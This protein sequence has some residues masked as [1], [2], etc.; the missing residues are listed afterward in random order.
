MTISGLSRVRTEL[1]QLLV[2]PFLAHHPIHLNG[3]FAGHRDLGDLPSPSP[4]SAPGRPTTPAGPRGVWLPRGPTRTPPSFSLRPPRHN[5]FLHRRP[6][7][8][9][10]AC[11]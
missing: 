5:L 2:I 8:S 4:P 3:E 11:S 6:S 9:A 10:T 1:S 7:L